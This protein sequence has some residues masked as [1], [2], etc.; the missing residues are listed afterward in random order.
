MGQNQQTFMAKHL[1]LEEQE[2]LDELKHFWK[3]YGN[4]ISW[5]LIAVL[6]AFA[7]WNGYQYWQR[8]QAAQAAV[9]YDEIER[10]VLS[11]EAARID[12]S[13]ADM[14]ER[15]GS[16]AY[17]QQAGLL[18]AKAYYDKGNADAARAALTWVADKASEPGYQAVAKLRLA[19]ILLEKKDYDQ[20]LLQLSG[21]FPKD[22]SGLVADRRGD[23]LMAQGKKAEARAEYEKAFK[24][25]GEYA[26][27]RRLVEVKLNALGV[28]P[29]AGQ[30]RL[31]AAEN[32]GINK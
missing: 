32:A 12:R 6:G 27:Y 8:N 19:G 23:V 4:L 5:A 26:E 28:D 17:A 16:T 14:K 13:L 2:Q 22:F 30:A 21:A 25:L 7:A 15:F 11:G 29:A 9:M 18:A 31:A 24:V 3:Q 20:A 10:A 1:D